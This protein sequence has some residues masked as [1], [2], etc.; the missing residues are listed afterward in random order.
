MQNNRFAIRTDKPNVKVSWVVLATRDDAY[1]RY[2]HKPTEF[3]KEP[4]HRGKYL[5]P[6]VYGKDESYGIFPG[7]VPMRTVEAKKADTFPSFSGKELRSLPE[8][9]LNLQEGEPR[10]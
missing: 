2:Y 8:K 5:N 6:Y 4:R 1:A 9:S 3:E 10:K 7:P